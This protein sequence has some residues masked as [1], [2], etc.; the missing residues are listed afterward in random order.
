MPLATLSVYMISKSCFN[1]TKIKHDCKQE[2]AGH[3]ST[4]EKKEKKEKDIVRV[5]SIQI[6]SID[7]LRDFC[8]PER[9]QL[10]PDLLVGRNA[11]YISVLGD[12]CMD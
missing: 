7:K 8:P 12:F 2:I 5:N 4:K 3:L 1:Y 10:L 11:A 6:E 9:K